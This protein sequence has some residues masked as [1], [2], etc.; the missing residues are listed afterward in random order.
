GGTG[1]SEAVIWINRSPVYLKDF[2]RANGIPDAF[3]TWINTGQ[4]TDVSPDGRILIG[5]GAPLGGFRGYMVILGSQ[6]AMPGRAAGARSPPWPSC[7]RRDARRRHSPGR[8]PSLPA[9]RHRRAWTAR[10]G[11]SISSTSAEGSPWARRRGTS[12]RNGGAPRS[13]G[14]GSTRGS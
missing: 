13:S 5:Y 2:L 14:R 4:I 10:P 3:D 9:S 6:L 7:C 8:R 12:S 1:D 11:S